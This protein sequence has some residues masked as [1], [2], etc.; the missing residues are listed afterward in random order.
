[1]SFRVLI[2]QD[3]AQE[4]KAYLRERGYQIVMGSGTSVEVIAREAADCDA[5]LA[6]TVSFPAAVLRAAPRLRVVARHGVGVD[7]IDVEIATELGIWVTNTPE[8]NA[9]SV[10]EHVI[11]VLVALARG[12]LAMDRAVRA[13]DYAA[14][15]RL[16][17]VDLAGKTLGVVGLGRIGRR[18]AALAAAGLGMA[19]AGHDPFLAEGDWPP[20]VRRIEG[21]EELLAASDF[22]TLH[23][24]G[25]A[26]TRRLIGERELAL[27]KPGAY[28]VNA[29]RGE[30]LEE[31]ALA[32]ALASGRLAGAGLDVF[33]PEPP[34][35]ENPLFA[36]ENVLV[37]PHSAALTSEALIRMAVGAAQGIH[38]VLSGAEPTWPVNRPRGR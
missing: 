17:A 28:L 13:G 7:N 23:V 11:G 10:A 14:R 22:L 26:G 20:G 6:R 12:F 30:V 25:T 37:T 38:E 18:V 27:M 2:P 5:I 34:S 32:D 19:V 29:S 24:P 21:L 16:R 9:V 8:A 3:V 15:G 1:M 31:A 33:D 4:G 35:P 36:L